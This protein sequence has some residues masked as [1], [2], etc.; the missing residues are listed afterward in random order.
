MGTESKSMQLWLPRCRDVWEK[1]NGA[2]F[3][4]LH[5]CLSFVCILGYSTH[6][7]TDSTHFYSPTIQCWWSVCAEEVTAC[8]LCLYTSTPNLIERSRHVPPVSLFLFSWTVLFFK[9]RSIG[10]F[11]LG[12]MYW[13]NKTNNTG[14]ILMIM[15]FIIVTII[16]V[17]IWLWFNL[18]IIYSVKL[19]WSFENRNG[20]RTTCEMNQ[21]EETLVDVYSFYLK[22]L[23]KGAEGSDN[24]SY[25]SLDFLRAQ[26]QRSGSTY[27]KR[28]PGQRARWNLTLAERRTALAPHL[29]SIPTLVGLLSVQCKCV[30]TIATFFSSPANKLIYQRPR[31]V[32]FFCTFT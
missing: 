15:F 17:F 11:L 16:Y 21:S 13:R 3:F 18:L 23:A 25:G 6:P 30:S 4:L 9:C 7:N 12:Q 14:V 2:I 29:I 20:G 19:T 8:F 1:P 27:W 28:S 24:T 32:Y 26:R 31:F 5:S 22:K 10:L